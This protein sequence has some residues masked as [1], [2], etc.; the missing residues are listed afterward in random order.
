MAPAMG[1]RSPGVPGRPDGSAPIA[2]LACLILL[3]FVLVQTPARGQMLPP[4]APRPGLAGPPKEED[5]T[6]VPDT[7]IIPALTISERYDSNVFFV[8]QGINLEDYVTTFNPK[9][10]VEHR[11]SWVAGNIYAGL[12]SEVYVNNPGLNYIAP[13]GGFAADLDGTVQRL[14]RRL[15][16]KM[17]DDFMYT[18]R[19]PSFAAPETGSVAPDAFVRGIQASRADSFSNIGIADGSYAF[20]D[21]SLYRA[22]Y[23]HQMI[24]FGNT[25]ATPGFGQ[26]FTT[27]FQTVN[28]GPE[29]QV[30][31]RDLLSLMY[32]YQRADF[33]GGGFGGGFDTHGVIGRW[34]RTLTS[35]FTIDLSAGTVVL[36]PSGD[37]QGVGSAKLEWHRENTTAEIGYSRMVVPSFFIGGL[38][39]QSQVYTGGITH[40][41]TD[42]VSWF[43]GG[44]YGDNR[45]IPDPILLFKSYSARTS[46]DWVLTKWATLSP[47]YTYGNYDYTLNTFVAQFDRHQ[48][49]LSL[50]MEWR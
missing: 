2:F 34:K 11:D 14:N 20:T 6:G 35:T 31:S 38:P 42:K 12:T 16:L 40:R 37:L 9:L 18:P 29:S 3:A 5:R 13:N 10:K 25:F 39:L 28:T 47:S 30:T 48:V 21:A 15:R 22:T 32:Q 36:L 45:S 8:G 19:P 17:S 24:R 33:D 41:F 26:F 46:L 50:R 43:V 23:T 4:A 49:M 44:D 7:Q 27:M 1:T